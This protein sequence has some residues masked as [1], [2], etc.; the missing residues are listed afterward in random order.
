MLAYVYDSEKRFALQD[1]PMPRER[2]DNA[3]LRVEACAI[4]GTDLRA[5]KFGSDSIAAP[6]ASRRA[7]M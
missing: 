5:H 6:R 2:E 4:C 3:I 7:I 1:V